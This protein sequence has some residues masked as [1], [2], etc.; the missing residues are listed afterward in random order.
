MQQ[1]A[2]EAAAATNPFTTFV[3]I[4]SASALSAY[5]TSGI[6]TPVTPETDAQA[7]SGEG[8]P[9]E[10]GAVAGRAEERRGAGEGSGGTLEDLAGQAEDT[11]APADHTRAPEPAMYAGYGSNARSVAVRATAGSVS[12]YA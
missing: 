2:G 10:S 6:S 11:R 1:G 4:Q 12:F 3:A 5:L 7:A 8:V 9:A